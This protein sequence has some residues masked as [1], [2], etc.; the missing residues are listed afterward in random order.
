MLLS[1]TLFHNYL[2]F[3]PGMEQTG[4]ITMRKHLFQSDRLLMMANE[5]RTSLVSWALQ[6]ES[7]TCSAGEMYAGTPTG[8]HHPGQVN[9]SSWNP[10]TPSAL[11]LSI[12]TVQQETQLGV[13]TQDG[14]SRNLFSKRLLFTLKPKG[15]HFTNPNGKSD[16]VIRLDLCGKSLCWVF[17]FYSY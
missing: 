13:T 11:R 17:C 16:R 5:A 14:A 1:S 7:Q 6:K 2:S 12:F 10:P 3:Q 9:G 15:N 8:I 4:A